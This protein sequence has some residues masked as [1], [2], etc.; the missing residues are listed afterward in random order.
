[1][2]I[3]TTYN[4]REFINCYSENIGYLISLIRQ[5]CQNKGY[6]ILEKEKL[7]K[8]LMYII[9]IHSDQRKLIY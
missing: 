2:T 1:M 4:Q 3:L 6:K 9:F 7:F 5:T 8:T